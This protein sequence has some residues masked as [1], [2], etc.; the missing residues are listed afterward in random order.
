MTTQLRTKIKYRY[1]AVGFGIRFATRRVVVDCY[2]EATLKFLKLNT[3]A[4]QR[5]AVVQGRS[6][7]PYRLRYTRCPFRMKDL[8]NHLASFCSVFRFVH[9]CLLCPLNMKL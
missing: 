7:S 2:T 8:C 5:E 9:F 6:L 3:Q 1:W 4:Q